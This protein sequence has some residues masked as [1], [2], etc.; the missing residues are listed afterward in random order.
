MHFK[1]PEVLYALLLLIIPILVHLFHL[2]KFKKTPFTNVKLLKKLQL[3]TRHSRSIKKWLVLTSRLLAITALVFTFAQPQWGDKTTTNADFKSIIYLDNSF[4]MHAKGQSGALLQKAAQELLETLPEETPL[5]FITNDQVL[6]DAE[7]NTIADLL[8]E[9]TKSP[10]ENNYSKTALQINELL[11]RDPEADYRIYYISDFQKKPEGIDAVLQLPQLVPVQLQAQQIGNISIDSLSILERS[12]ETLRLSVALSAQDIGPKTSLSVFK[13]DLLESK[14]S[15]DFTEKT[16]TTEID[17]SYEDSTSG[18]LSIDDEGL[19]FDNELYF[20]LD[21]SSQTKVLAIN[22]GVSDAFLKK[23]YGENT[24]QLTSVSYRQANFNAFSDQNFIVLNQIKN[25]SEALVAALK[26]YHQNGGSLCI[27]LPP[28]FTE[29]RYALTQ[30]FNFGNIEASK[31]S[32][33]ITRIDFEHPIFKNVF[34]KS[35]DNFQY[36]STKAAVT[37]S[38]PGNSIIAYE[39]GTP[40]V[41]ERNRVYVVHSPLDRDYANFTESP[42]IVPLFDN[43]ARN[44][45]MPSEIYYPIGSDNRIRIETQQQKDKVL[46]ISKN[47]YRFIPQQRVFS[48]FIEVYTK[49]SPAESGIYDIGFEDAISSRLAYNYPRTENRLDYYTAEDFGNL[50]PYASFAKAYQEISN[51]INNSSLW[52]W[53]LGLALLFLLIESLLLKFLK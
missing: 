30:A 48:N 12:A 42:I 39:D 34:E 33:L 41:S 43:M 53:F 49:E 28:E 52:K 35:I 6:Q 1:H 36:P 10:L 22:D 16:I 26:T 45:K 17:L 2:R 25:P 32:K 21:F 20:H 27:I 19:S 4:S 31:Q 44:S 3:Q 7:R 50:K 46:Q 24:Y 47:E 5:H 18:Y 37:L 8:W 13:N 14:I 51:K 9:H 40:F 11:Q 29:N 38:Y 23:L 15:L